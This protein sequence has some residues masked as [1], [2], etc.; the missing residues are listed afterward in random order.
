MYG[1]EEEQIS[2]EEADDN[3]DSVQKVEVAVLLKI[4][5]LLIKLFNLS[6]SLE[7]TW[8]N[9]HFSHPNP[10]ST[11]DSPITVIYPKDYVDKED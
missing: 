5:I 4:Q 1:Y 2:Y 3:K 8:F 10:A 6:F 11:N 7:K 9:F